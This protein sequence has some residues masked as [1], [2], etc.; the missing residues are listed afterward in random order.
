MKDAGVNIIVLDTLKL[1]PSIFNT[2]LFNT[3]LFVCVRRAA[4]LE[5]VLSVAYCTAVY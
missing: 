3:S 2:S 1:S 5:G 4:P